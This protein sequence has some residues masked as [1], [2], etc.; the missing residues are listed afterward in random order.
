MKSIAPVFLFVITS[1]GSAPEDYVL[2]E[3]AKVH[4]EAITVSAEVATALKSIENQPDALSDQQKDELEKLKQDFTEWRDLV[5]EVPGYEHEEHNHHGHDHR[6]GPNELEGLP[7]Q[8]ILDIQ[9]ELKNQ[10]EVLN[11]KIEAF[12]KNQTPGEDGV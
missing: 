2:I 6:H 10:I 7:S 9:K 8:Q 3:A 11:S 4:D 12:S 5:V 1:C